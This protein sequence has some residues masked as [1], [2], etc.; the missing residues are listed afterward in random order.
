[1]PTKAHAAKPA[2]KKK[3]STIGAIYDKTK[4][5]VVDLISGAATGAV[6]GAASSAV[7]AVGVKTPSSTKTSN[8]KPASTKNKPAARSSAKKKAAKPSAATKTKSST[9]RSTRARASK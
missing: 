2:K 7:E 3:E 1:M 4:E 5:V 6:V 9:K 8:G